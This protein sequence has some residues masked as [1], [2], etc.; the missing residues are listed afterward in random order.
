MAKEFGIVSDRKKDS[1]PGRDR[2][3]ARHRL[4]ILEE[5]TSLVGRT[6]D[7]QEALEGVVSLVATAMDCEVCS[8]YSFDGETE[9]LSLAATRGLPARSIGR[10]MMSRGEGLVGL[11]VEQGGAVVVEDA[12]AHPRFKFF[13]ELGEEKYHSFAGA[14]VGE[15]EGLIGVLVLQSRRRRLFTS[16]ETTLLSSM[17]GHLRPV[18]VSAHLA[19]RLQREEKERE[20]YRRGMVRAIQR[21]EAHE[22]GE[23]WRHRAEDSEIEVHLTGQGVS[24]GFGL[25]RVHIVLPPADIDHVT[26]HEGDPDVELKRF[27]DALGRAVAEVK[28]ASRHMRELVPA[29]GG[30]IYEALGMVIEDQS[31]KERIHSRIKHGL[32]AESALKGVVEEYVE[33]FNAMEDRYLRERAV[34][35]RDVGQRILRYLLGVDD[36]ADVVGGAKDA[37]L[38]TSELTLSDLST[39]DPSRLRA[40]VSASGGA[41]SHA[42]ILAKSLEI[43]TVVGAHGILAACRKG[44]DIIVD[45][46]TGTVYLR[47]GPEVSRQ[48]QRLAGQFRDFQR[49]LEELRDLPCETLDGHRISL[50][51]N[52]GLLAELDF[53]KAHGAEGIGLYRTEFPFLSYR[54]FP[55]EEEQLLLYRKVIEKMNGKPVTIRT[56]DLGGDKYPAYVRHDKEQNPFLG[57]RSIRL[58]LENESLFQEQLRAILHAAEDTPLRILFP[59]ITSVE[60]LRRI[61]EIYAECVSDVAAVSGR[62]PAAIEL[63]A[64]IEVP[65]AVMQVSQIL[66]EV[67]FVS[68]G[69]NDLIQYTLAVDRD[70]R[71]TA[72]MYEALHPAILRSI[73]TVA[74][75]AHEAGRRVA[76]CGE[77]AADPM[78]TLFLLG[79]GMDELSM[80]P[81]HIPVIKKMVRAVNL[82]DAEMFAADMLRY[83][84]VED[85]KGYI[86]AG[87]RELGLIELV[88][89]F[90]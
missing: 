32:A 29:V 88:E 74:E 6:D 82:S 73:K 37:V 62:P 55:S 19:E 31:F 85:I 27:D 25:G 66:R 18:M 84:T 38:V 47:P 17:A 58:S 13:P 68:I 79:V 72:S 87:L 39:V 52:I 75:A 22:T 26:V 34:D 4:E 21:L 64:M 60:E 49:E 57:W 71:K 90:S 40:I 63:G 56:L 77:M 20:I 3:T 76:L 45:G 24:P 80:G 46:N 86:F 67:D 83:D 1:A 61:R 43:P 78:C 5:I 10:I 9:T 69:T 30:D 35:V 81:L 15:G 7:Y 54:D 53:A 59:M 12:L 23:S 65:S 89:S 50:L 14:P 51:A 48:Y 36:S 70:N 16:E 28:T 11:V 8:L 2:G 44:D 42:A 41:T 33:R